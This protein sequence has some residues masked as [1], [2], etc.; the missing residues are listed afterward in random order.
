MIDHFCSQ[1]EIMWTSGGLF[2]N[3][4][5]LNMQ[6]YH[7]SMHELGSHHQKDG[8]IL[9]RVLVLTFLILEKR[10]YVLK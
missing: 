8:N 7:K 4:T 5:T 6:S 3:L 9:N 2:L 1:D 10:D